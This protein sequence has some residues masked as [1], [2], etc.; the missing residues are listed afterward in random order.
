M[1][2]LKDIC[3]YIKIPYCNLIIESSTLFCFN[4]TKLIFI[5]I[6]L[7]GRE[8]WRERVRGGGGYASW[9]KFFESVINSAPP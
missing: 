5:L 1:R 9:N 2:S 6:S 3:K 7:R 8:G 4:V